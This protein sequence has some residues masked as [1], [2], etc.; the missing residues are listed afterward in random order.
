[1]LVCRVVLLVCML[2]EEVGC[3]EVEEG[4]EVVDR[5]VVSALGYL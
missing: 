1:M 4:V 3:I 2:G 5:V